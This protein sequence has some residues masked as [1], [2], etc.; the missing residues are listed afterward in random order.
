MAPQ[1]FR[2]VELY[3]GEPY[4]RASKTLVE[5]TRGRAAIGKSTIVG[6]TIAIVVIAAVSALGYLTYVR[7]QCSGYPPGGNCPRIYNYTFKTSINYS[8]E[9]KQIEYMYHATGRSSPGPGNYTGGLALGTGP[10]TGSI[11]VSGPYNSGLTLCIVAEK[12]DSSNA[13]LVFGIDGRTNET[14]LPYGKATLCAGVV[15]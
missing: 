10:S 8:G 11:T 1:M 15:P 13:S 12:L 6:I 14:S 5:R 7:T 3:E 2:T 9:W 4:T